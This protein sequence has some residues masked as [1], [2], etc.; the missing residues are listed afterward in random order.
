MRRCLLAILLFKLSFLHII[1]QTPFSP[2]VDSLIVRGIDQTFDCQFDSAMITFQKVIDLY[3]DHAAGYF[4]KAA[5]LQSKMMDYETDLWENEY[6][7]LINQ[8][9]K[10]GEQQ[11]SNED[12]NPWTYFYLGSSYGY[13]GLYQAATGSYIVGFMS[14]REGLGF[15]EEAV[16]RNEA[17][18][19]AYMVL[20]NYKY[21]Y[22]RFKKYFKWIPLVRDERDEGIRMIK[23]SIVKGTFSYWVGMNS[24][25]WI[26]YDQK[27][28]KAAR[29]L[30]LKGLDQYPGSRF[31]MWGLAD[32][33][34]RMDEYT[35]AAEL[36]ESLLDVVQNSRWNNGYN[37]IVARFKLIRTYL[38]Q[39]KYE[40]ALRHCDSLLER[41]V[42]DRVAQRINK[43]LEKTKQY[44]NQCLKHLR[45]TETNRE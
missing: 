4:Y 21:W 20:G 30:F 28:Y 8:A 43:R 5:T 31:F 24:L 6:Y 32:T 38:A 16:K 36:Y 17:V 12:N 11:I 29:N 39:K 41:E 3:P 22:S 44:R 13:K 26:E 27:H 25:A 19:D 37:E 10:L 40:A 14:A 7:E 45:R 35:K 34:F 9:I 42:D 23:L 1:A 15:M 33:Y 18:Y 2:E